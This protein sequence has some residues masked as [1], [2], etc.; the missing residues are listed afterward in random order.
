MA[1]RNSDSS[2]N[3]TLVDEKEQAGL[4]SFPENDYDVEKASTTP[5]TINHEHT[6]STRRKLLALA[7]YFFCNVGLTIYN[8]AVLGSVCTTHS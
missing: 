4:L 5:P 3:E 6:V 1:S 2:D 8:K 7:G